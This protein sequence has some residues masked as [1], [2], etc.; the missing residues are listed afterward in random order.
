MMGS[1]LIPQAESAAA[2]RRQ[3]GA[4]AALGGERHLRRAGALRLRRS[5]AAVFTVVAT[6][7]LKGANFMANQEDFT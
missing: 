3:G 7:P 1:F 2:E 5:Q 6:A 4:G